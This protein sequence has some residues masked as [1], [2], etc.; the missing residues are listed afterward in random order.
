LEWIRRF[1]P[2]G[3][4][5]TGAAMLLVACASAPIAPYVD[6]TPPT[7]LA[8][9]DDVGVRDLRAS[10]RAAACRQLPANSPACDDV[11]LRLPDEEAGTAPSPPPDLPQR[12]RIAFVPGFL[13]ECFDRFA[14]PFADAQRSLEAEG[15]AVDYFRVPGRGTTADGAA[16]LAAHF[17]SL[18]GDPRPIILF[19]YSK[20]LPDTLEFVVRYPAAARRIAAIVGVAGAANGSPLADDLGSAY[21]ELAAGFP[22]AGCASGTGAEIH[23]LRRDVRLAWWRKNRAAVKTPVFALVAAPRPDRVSPATRLTYDRLARQDPRNDGKLLAQDQIVPGGYLLG[24]V[25][26]DHWAIAI[27]LDEALPWLSPLYRDNVPRPALVRGAIDVVAE[28]LQPSPRLSRDRG[29]TP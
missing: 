16:K 12:Y 15:F 2:V 1:I 5:A 26:A 28:T 27:P 4:A 6:S 10:Y 29:E 11:L 23:D 22:L 21:R 19:A 25:N 14:R 20:G 3:T 18:D 24:Y 7:V 9:I 8:T 17:A 13:S